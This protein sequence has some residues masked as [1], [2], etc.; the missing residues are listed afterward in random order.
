LLLFL[1]AV[2]VTQAD[3]SAMPRYFDI[4]A[5]PMDAA[6]IEFS[7]QADIQLM[8]ATELV[9][10]LKSKGVRGRHLPEDALIALIAGT[11]LTFHAVGKNAIAVVRDKDE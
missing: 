9:E 10:N 8:I 2:A 5:Q 4:R 1:L 3:D 7:E 11:G 6:L